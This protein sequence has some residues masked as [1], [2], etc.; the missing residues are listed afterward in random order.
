ML[1]MRSELNKLPAI[2]EKLMALT[3][4]IEHLG[5]QAEK[6]QQ[7]MLRFMETTVKERSMMSERITESNMRDSMAMKM[8][9]QIHKLTDFE[10]MIV[11]TISIDGPVLDWVEN[12]EI[13][14]NQANL[15]GC[16]GGKY[17]SNPSANTKSNVV[18][19]ASDDK[20]NTT[21]PMRT[22]AL[23]GVM[24]RENWKEG[25]SKRLSNA[26]FQARREKGLCFRCN[27]KYSTN[28]KYKAKE[29]REL[30]MFV[31]KSDKEELEIIEK[32][33]VEKKELNAIEITVRAKRTA[34]KGKGIC[35]AIELSLNEW[36][37]N[38]S[39]PEEFNHDIHKSR[40]EGEADQGF[41]IEFRAL[42]GGMTMAEIE[43]HIHLKKGTDPLVCSPLEEGWKLTFCVDYRALNNV[44]ILDKFPI[45]VIEELFDKMNGA[46]MFS[47]I[48]KAGYHQICMCANDAEKTAFRMHEG[49]YEFLVMPFGM[50]NAPSTFQSLM[51]TRVEVDSEKIRAIAEWPSPTNVREVRGF[52]GLTNYYSHHYGTTAAPLTQLLKAGAFKWSEEAE[53]AF[54]GL[55]NAMM[56]LHV[57]ALPDFSLPF[58]I[59]TDASGYGIGAVLIQAKRPIAY[60]SQTLAMR[61]KAKPIYE[62]VL[63]AV[64]L[65]YQ[66]WIDKLLGYSFEVVY[67]PELENKAADALSRMPPTIHL[68][69]LSALT[70]IDL[71][72]IE[73]LKKTEK[74]MSELVNQEVEVLY[75]ARDVKIVERIGPVTYKPEL[76][77]SVAIHPVFHV[78]QLKKMLGVHVAVQ[79]ITPYVT[80]NHEWKAIPDEVYR[81]QKNK[82]GG[83]EVLLSWKGLPRHEAT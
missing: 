4:N 57:L 48:V 27:E 3:K 36:R 54:M 73:V 39:R 53:E 55:K 79:P 34:I 47:K 1:G 68:Y 40:Q 28:H 72:V 61:D 70:I 31:V 43:H 46:A 11:A 75:A 10:K 58:E 22:I 67:K 81:Y 8:Y 63:M 6:Q 76:P 62:R 49:H 60:Y 64:V 20:S 35:E 24:A 26:E 56:T 69:N 50:T 65:A 33:E 21:F 51:N 19:N 78:S 16:S 5:V 9:F 44:M 12:R 17:N 83:W 23:K 29:Q 15:K 52:L 59:E 42:I 41:L 2:E 45:P 32:D 7:F 66:K 30:R 18:A 25:R 38:R 37:S 71:K 77:S 74:V 80:E 82:V 13:I 14:R